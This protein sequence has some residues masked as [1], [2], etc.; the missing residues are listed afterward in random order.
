MDRPCSRCKQAGTEYGAQ[1]W[2]HTRADDGT[3]V[4]AQCWAEIEQTF[5]DLLGVTLV[6]GAA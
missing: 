1:I 3:V 4:C 6:T 2:V 5:A